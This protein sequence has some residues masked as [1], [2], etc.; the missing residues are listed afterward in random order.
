MC[1]CCYNYK[2][3]LII[4]IIRSL[5]PKKNNFTKFAFI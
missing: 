3:T 1:D 2:R 4:N 5:D